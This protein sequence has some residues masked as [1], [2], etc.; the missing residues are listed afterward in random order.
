MLEI[1]QSLGT[2][3]IDLFKSPRRLE[4]ENLFLRHQLTIP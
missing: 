1:L 2:F 4:A 3:I